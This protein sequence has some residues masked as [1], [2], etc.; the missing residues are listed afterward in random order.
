MKQI[1]QIFLEGES[2]TLNLEQSVALRM[3]LS[4]NNFEVNI[5][6]SFTY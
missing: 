3:S 2:P 1:T 5:L 4:F 6:D